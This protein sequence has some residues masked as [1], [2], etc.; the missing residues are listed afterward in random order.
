M[1]KGLQ[2][3]NGAFSFHNL[4]SGLLGF[5]QPGGGA[6]GSVPAQ[7]PQHNRCGTC[8]LSYQQFAQVGRFGCADCYKYFNNRL[9]PLVRRIHGGATHHTGKVPA[10]TGGVLKQRKQ[11]DSLRRDLQNKIQAEQFE[12]A[13]VLRDRIRELESQ[14]DA[15][16]E[17]V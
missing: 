12:E 15:S 9:D 1:M 2:G 4:L 11:L 5:E 6:F 14:M 3:A 16:A 8:G 17:G 7:A 10:R 13:A